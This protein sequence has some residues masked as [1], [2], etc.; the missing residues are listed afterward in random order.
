MNARKHQVAYRCTLLF[1]LRDK[2]TERLM[3][4]IITLTFLKRGVLL[5]NTLKNRI[6]FVKTW[7][8]SWNTIF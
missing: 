8:V 4:N 7:F 1:D 6:F 2:L 5:K 3:Q